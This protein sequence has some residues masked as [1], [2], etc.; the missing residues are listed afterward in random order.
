MWVSLAY[1]KVTGASRSSRFVL[2]FCTFI[3]YRS[4]FMPL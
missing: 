2:P 4:M 3:L 1:P